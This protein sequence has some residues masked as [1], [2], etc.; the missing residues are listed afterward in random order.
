MNNFTISIYYTYFNHHGFAIN[1]DLLDTNII[2]IA[3]LLSALIYFGKQSLNAILTNRQE[4]VFLAL[5][6]TENKLEQANLRLS[7]AEK[8]LQQTQIVIGQIKKEAEITANKIKDS[9]LA[10]GKIDLERLSASSKS[11]IISAEYAIRRQIQQQITTLAL[12]R[13]TIQLKGQMNKD[14]QKRIID[15]N[16]AQLGGKL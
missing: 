6:E 8:Q 1:T 16:I 4:K 2:N 5:Q 9:I 14:I 12:K 3:I 11:N 13:V 15:N 7:E 10:Q